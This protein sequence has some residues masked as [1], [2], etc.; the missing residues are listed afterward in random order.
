MKIDSVFLKNPF[1]LAPLAGYTDLAFRLLCRETGAGLVVS[2]M[3]SCHGLVYGQEKTFAML[4][5]M[6]EER[7]WAIQLFGNEAGIMGRPAR[8]RPARGPAAG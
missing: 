4:Q 6:P 5:T 3:I 8:A 1:I 7:P 2:E